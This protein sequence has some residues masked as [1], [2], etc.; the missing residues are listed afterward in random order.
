MPVEGNDPNAPPPDG[1]HETTRYEP[2]EDAIALG[3][4]TLEQHGP[5][6]W[7]QKAAGSTGA[8]GTTTGAS[9]EGAAPSSG[10]AVHELN[11][12]IERSQ[13]GGTEA[14]DGY[15]LI[16]KLGTGSFG[17]VWEA[18]DRLTGEHVAI[19]FFTTGDTDWEKLLG[20]VRLLQTVEGCPGIVMVKQVRAGGPGQRPHYVM[21]LANA[22]SLADWIKTA[23]ALPP[24]ERVR[25]AVS[26]FTRVARA[27]AAVHR[28]GILHCDLKPQNIL[29]HSA[30]PT[31]PPEPLVADFGQAHLGTDDT[32]ALGTFFYM[33]PDQIDAAQTG[34]PPDTRWDVYALG[35]LVY[36]LLTGEVPRRSPELVERIKK[37]PKH[38]PT[39]MAVY[40][41]GLLAAPRPEAHHKIADPIL[42]KIIDRCLNLQPNQRPADAG[43]LV[44]LLDARARWR[45]TRPLLGLA[46]TASFLVIALV[47]ALGLLAADKVTTRTKENVTSEVT[48]SLARTAGYGT[49]AVE[50]RLRRHVVS[51]EG[52]AADSHKDAAPAIKALQEGTKE[53]RGAR[54]PDR[55]ALTPPG[56]AAV[57]TWLANL[58]EQRKRRAG[59]N[60][61]L[62]TL[63]VMLVTDG[64][65]AAQ[66]RGFYVARVPQDG[67]IQDAG[68]TEGKDREFF[69]AD[70][71]YRDYFH[72]GPDGEAPNDGNPHSVI[73]FTHIS[74]PFRSRGVDQS[75][76]GVQQRE[77][78]KLNVATPIWDHPDPQKRTRVIGLLILGLD[79]EYDVKP[80]LYPTEYRDSGGEHAGYG[81]DRKVKVVVTDH[82][83]RWVWHPDS[84][85]VLNDDRPEFRHPPAYPELVRKHG[86]TGARAGPWL[87]L[88]TP[89]G[90]GPHLY[91]ESDD[92][93]DAMEAELSADRG[94]EIACFTRF[95]PY[96][97]SRYNDP[98]LTSHPPPRRWVF[99][100]QVDRKAA[101]RPLDDMK[102]EILRG[103]IAVVGA[104]TLIAV[105]LWVGL[106]MVL[107]RLEFASHG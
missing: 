72:A 49:R 9:E 47:T 35:A 89:Q 91:T 37:S 106:V 64:T 4:G 7:V 45:R 5:P 28:R 52:W 18:E 31:A 65:G 51:V 55:P 73:R 81:I 36:E 43:A 25:V 17:A 59:P 97:K 75:D 95:D 32:P 79:V 1:G 102:G 71:S 101:L 82:R 15:T 13:S 94:E 66:S 60:E 99:V 29:L 27:M 2:D 3:G 76:K 41:D 26:F 14:A 56:Q 12:E 33:P 80:L 40:R 74:H 19:K 50:D 69:L 98:R 63:G 53:A 62:P 54:L 23:A 30:D 67:T 88:D 77:R 70:L 34:T 86:L 48:G 93:V 96:D 84:A 38:L 104:L 68:N 85:A 16:K 107:R 22:G 39:R 44:A 83:G 21:Q 92:Y 90:S 20:E 8:A 57:R 103:G 10:K 87:T 78:W 24:R 42:A 46:A 11:R 58:H 61:H 100:A 105:G 6:S